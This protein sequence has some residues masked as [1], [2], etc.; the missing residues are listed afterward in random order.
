MAFSIGISMQ[1]FKH[2][3]PKK[4]GYCLKGY[5]ISQKRKDEEMWRMGLY[6]QSAVSTAIEHNLAGKKAKSKYVERP[7]LENTAIK[8]K[9]MT[10]NEIKQKRLS[11]ISKMSVMKA[12]F[13]STKKEE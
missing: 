10:E 8:D 12:N 3:T 5:G 1:E 7:L 4:L 13:D 9:E 11:F 2:L 6:V